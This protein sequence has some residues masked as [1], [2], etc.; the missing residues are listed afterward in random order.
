MIK[1]HR[2]EKKEHQASTGVRAPAEQMQTVHRDKAGKIVT[3]E[4]KLVTDKDR[5]QQTNKAAL[6]TWA[7][8]AKQIQDK[9]K[10]KQDIEE[11]KDSKFGN[12][13]LDP[14]VERNLKDKDRFGDP[15]KLMQSKTVRYGKSDLLYRVLTV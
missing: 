3:L 13:T 14:E 11:A 15:L 2:A 9:V 5:L 12:S 8:G 10:I 4:E 1:S 6:K 7:R